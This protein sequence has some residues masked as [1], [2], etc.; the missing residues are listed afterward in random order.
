MV[1][2]VKFLC[3]LARGA[4]ALT[5]DF[6]EKIL[7]SG[8]IPDPDDYLLRDEAAEKQYN[9]NLQRSEARA[10]SN[11]GGLLQGIPVFCTDKVRNGP[12]SYRSI[13]EA[14]GAIFKLYRARSGTVIKPTTAEEDG[15][16]APE[17][18]Y[19]LSTVGPEEQQLWPR[20]KDMAAK[21]NMEPRIVAP[22]WLLDVAMAQQVRFDDR[23]LVVNFH[24]DDLK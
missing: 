18:V 7:D 19:L 16:A 1:R 5:T 21:G 11:R 12:E 15:N 17:P 2:T 20:F 6:V 22:D 14:N 9:M 13:A 8:E 3:A 10:K 4:T 23:F 24:R